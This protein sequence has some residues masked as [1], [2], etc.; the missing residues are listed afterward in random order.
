LEVDIDAPQG[1]TLRATYGSPVL[2]MGN[3][4]QQLATAE[5]DTTNPLIAADVVDWSEP[6]QFDI[7]VAVDGPD[8]WAAEHSG[9]GV[10]VDTRRLPLT[11]TFSD[12]RAGARH[13]HIVG[14]GD[15]GVCEQRL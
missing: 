10:R 9:P 1:W 3:A 13:V 5:I 8:E 6:D 12:S 4:D 7:A 2:T 14:G 15:R 11:S